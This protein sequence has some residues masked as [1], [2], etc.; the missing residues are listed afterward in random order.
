MCFLL[1][2]LLLL[3][4]LLGPPVAIVAANITLTEFELNI[5][6]LLTDNGSAPVT[7]L[8]ISI[9][10]DGPN[11]KVPLATP[12]INSTQLINKATT[13]QLDDLLLY[14]YTLIIGVYNQLATVSSLYTQEFVIPSSSGTHMYIHLHVY[15]SYIYL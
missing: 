9:E 7:G 14:T 11:Q 15:N 6:C 12:I 13:I 5:D 2:W 8:L 10:P 3:L 1:Q 4:S